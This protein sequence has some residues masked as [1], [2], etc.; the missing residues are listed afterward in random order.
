M[1]GQKFCAWKKS[2]SKL[3]ISL[4][5]CIGDVIRPTLKQ[6][7]QGNFLHFFS[8]TLCSCTNVVEEISFIRS[9]ISKNR[10]FLQNNP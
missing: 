9:V 3:E 2:L 6:N 7:S 4:K 5:I 1:P 10:K 8:V